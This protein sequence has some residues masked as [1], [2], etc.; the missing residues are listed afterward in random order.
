V[1]AELAAAQA[2]RVGR[3]QLLAR[4]ITRH[5]I[6]RRL[7]SG[8]LHPVHRGV[9]AAG[10][11]TAGPRAAV[12]SAW[13]A[14]GPEAVVSHRSAA[15]EHGIL[16]DG[17]IVVDVTVP[18]HLRARAGIGVHQAALDPRDRAVAGGLPVTSLARTL[19]D[20]ATV[21][22][23]KD[24]TRAIEQAEKM[25]TLDWAALEDVI[26]RSNGHRGVGILGR[27]M[28]G[29]DPRHLRTRS[30]WERDVLP[31]LDALGLPRPVVNRR[32]GPYEF[33]LAWPDHRLVVE[34]DSFEHHRDRAAFEADRARDRWLAARGLTC[35]RFTWRQVRDGAL[36]ELVGL[37]RVRGR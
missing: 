31:L 6:E 36:A 12:F 11:A 8:H 34:L 3:W 5:A 21:C 2:G 4:G 13:L 17:R 10:H 9:Y 26:A 28:A 24:V 22:P 16:R 30:G 18:R 25:G 29:H 19:L 33:D 15:G 14:V 23:A 1:I 27:A 37:L 32:L 35:L 20:I 7:A